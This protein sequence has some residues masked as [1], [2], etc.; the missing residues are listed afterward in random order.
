MAFIPDPSV[1]IIVLNWNG[2]DY[3]YACL[4]S[5]QNIDYPNFN[6]ILVDNASHNQEG[7]RLKAD[8]PEVDLIINAQ[9]LGFSG[10]NNVG[11]QSALDQ[12][13]DYIMLLNNDTEV[14]RNFLTEMIHTMK[15]LPDTGIVQ[16]LICF[17][18]SRNQVWSAGGKWV[19][20][21]G[22][23]VTMGDRKTLT[24]YPLKDK[25]LDWATGCCMLISQ[26]AVVKT[27][28]LNEK[29]FAYFEDVEWSL[30]FRKKGFKITLASK[31]KIYH[32]AGA[33]SKKKHSEGT[34]SPRVFYFHVRN[35]LFLVR[36]D[37]PNFFK[38]MAVLYHSARFFL[39]MLYFFLR[40]RFR[41]LSAVAKGFKDGIGT[42]LKRY[43]K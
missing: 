41:K 11:I 36:S 43:P 17:L 33:S 24:H 22:R 32:A 21:L 7:V 16:P 35:Q 29:Y 20:K 2:Y 6:V 28:L 3:T 31:A 26:D 19:S 23:A 1:A 25:T 34:L 15:G 10:G 30:R 18:D 38:P 4:S 13:Y 27:G 8:F 40:G 39:W 5:L 37:V 12:G 9:N 14:E 42:P